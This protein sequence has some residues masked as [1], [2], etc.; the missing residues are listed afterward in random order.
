MGEMSL[1]NTRFVALALLLGCSSCGGK[2]N[3]EQQAPE[4]NGGSSAGGASNLGGGGTGA[5]AGIG[6]PTTEC[7]TVIPSQ[8]AAC[9]FKGTQCGYSLSKCSSVIFKCLAGS[10]QQ[11]TVNS[12][13]AVTCAFYTGPNQPKDG[14]SCECR[15]ALDCTFDDCSGQGKVHAVC[16]D[17]SWHVTSA[18]CAS[19]ACGPN[20]LLCQVGEV[21]VL[22]QRL[23]DTYACKADPCASENETTSC[24]CAASVC[25]QGETCQVRDGALQ[26]SCST[27]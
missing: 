4:P 22:P 12:G 13:A 6:S 9:D 8:G 1:S 23:A 21:C 17:T 24:D 16:D 20:G 7:P 2:S 27:C 26:C 25:A 3:V 18:P 15:G 14:D 11:L 5:A 10:W 19:S